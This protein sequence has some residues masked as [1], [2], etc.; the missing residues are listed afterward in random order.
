MGSSSVSFS[1]LTAPYLPRHCAETLTLRLESWIDTVFLTMARNTV[2]SGQ[3]HSRV[4]I[5]ACAHYFA[6]R[7]LIATDNETFTLMLLCWTP[8]KESPI[9]D[10]P[11]EGCWMR[12]VQG[13]VR[14][15][16]VRLRR[17]WLLALTRPYAGHGRTLDGLL[18]PPVLLSVPFAL[19]CAAK[20][21]VLLPLLRRR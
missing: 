20:A 1:R 17:A 9:H 4:A 21:A 10:H 8:G 15:V 19:V 14:E 7:N 12:V 3:G 2:S 16:Q 13:C 5:T 18:R 11:C 6:A